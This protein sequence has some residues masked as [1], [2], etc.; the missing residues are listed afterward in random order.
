MDRFLG[1][2]MSL[3]SSLDESKNRNYLYR[4]FIAVQYGVMG[5]HNRIKKF[6]IALYL[7][8]VPIVQAQME[9]T[10]AFVKRANLTMYDHP[11]KE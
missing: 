1:E 8:F 7:S 6:L 10:P 4:S 2:L 3:D 11:S 5:K 9:T